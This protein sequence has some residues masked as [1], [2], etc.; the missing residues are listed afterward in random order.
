MITGW[1]TWADT[2]ICSDGKEN[3]HSYLLSTS[4]ARATKDVKKTVTRLRDALASESLAIPMLI[5]IAQQRNWYLWFNYDLK[6]LF[7]QFLHSVLSCACIEEHPC[8]SLQ[9]RRWSLI[10]FPL[11]THFRKKKLFIFCFVLYCYSIVF[12]QESHLKL[13]GNFYDGCQETLLQ[14]LDFLSRHFESEFS[15]F[16]WFTY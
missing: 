5:L 4:Q 6:I 12:K 16:F 1:K 3:S 15:F 14:Y 7:E 11:S 13:K 9:A 8:M 10:V 2:K